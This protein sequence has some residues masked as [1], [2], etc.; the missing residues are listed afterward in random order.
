MLEVKDEDGNTFITEEEYAEAVAE[1]DNGLKFEQ[2]KFSTQSDL[3]FLEVDAIDQVVEDLMEEYDIDRKAAVDCIFTGI[4]LVFPPLWK[5]EFFL[6]VWK[7]DC[8]G[9]S[10]AVAVRLYLPSVLRGGNQLVP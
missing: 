3:S 2:G 8:H 4:F 9:S 7:L 10:D 5:P 1:V 6:Y